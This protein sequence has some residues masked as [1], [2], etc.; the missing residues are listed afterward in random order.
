MGADDTLLFNCSITNHSEIPLQVAPI[1]ETHERSIYGEIAD[2]EF[3]EADTVTLQPYEETR[4]SFTI[5]KAATPQAYAVRMSLGDHDTKE[6]NSNTVI[7]Y[8]AI[9]GKNA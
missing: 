6:R 9:Q 1:F 3:L 7:G 5:P 8:S 2:V 4:L